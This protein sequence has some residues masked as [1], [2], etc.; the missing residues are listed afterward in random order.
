M[1]RSL[2]I[3]ICDFLLLSLLALANFDVTGQGEK[4]GPGP[5][6]SM[7]NLRAEQDLIEVLKLSLE[8]ERSSRDEL[9]GDL[10]L[11][12][13]EL[14]ERERALAEREARLAE[15]TLT[16]E[17]REEELQRLAQD[18]AELTARVE[19]VERDAETLRREQAAS[20][21]AARRAREEFL[22][23][24][25]DLRS[26][27]RELEETQTHLGRLEELQREAEEA[28]RRLSTEL[29]LSET[30]KRLIRENLEQVRS[31]VAIVR[32]EKDRIQEQARE[33][34]QGVTTLAERSGELTE[35]IRRAQPKTAATI[36]SEFQQNRLNAS[37]SA[38]RAGLLGQ[39]NRN[40]QTRTVLVTDGHQT[41]A[42]LHLEET[43]LSLNDTADWE[44]F[45]GRIDDGVR[46]LPVRE[47]HFLSIDPRVAVV[48]V[49]ARA[50]EVFG[51]AVYPVSTEPFKFPEAVLIAADGS[52]YGEST[53]TVNADTPR[54]VRMPNRITTRLF[55]DF[56]PSRGD[57]VFSKTGELLG[58]MVNHETCV[59]IDN[60][61]PAATLRTGEDIRDQNTTATLSRLR[62]RVERLPQRMR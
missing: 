2:L 6:V 52:Y 30:E 47:V 40:R 25:R 13:E 11:V 35:E 20:E 39:V 16:A 46:Q 41:F 24:E 27:M 36:F 57:L 23:M 56:S 48:P 45:Q 51:T 32:G 33:L 31:E 14:A 44:R 9:T 18:R 59:V 28:N 62:E 1:S 54:H 10:E 21:E 50:A 60:F 55:G 58:I 26:K 22:A 3:V 37:F 12:R 5:L 7:E 8:T 15:V 49:D 34:A 29:E 38:R 43:G 61:L 42:L 53:F 17:E 19:E 4:E